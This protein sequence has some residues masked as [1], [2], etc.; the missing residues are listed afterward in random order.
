MSQT[1]FSVIILYDEKFIRKEIISMGLVDILVSLA[2][3][4]LAGWIAGIIMKSKSGLLLNIILGL[5]GGIVGGWVLSL[6]KLSLPGILGSIIG[7]VIGACLVIF[8]VRLFKK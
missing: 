4:A 2:L 3:G 8:V 5:V 7:A 6:F 1:G